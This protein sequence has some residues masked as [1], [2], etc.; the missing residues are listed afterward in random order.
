MLNNQQKQVSKETLMEL[1]ST[2]QDEISPKNTE[3]RI[4]SWFDRNTIEGEWIEP[5]FFLFNFPLMRDNGDIWW[6]LS[7]GDAI[8]ITAP[9]ATWEGKKAREAIWLRNAFEIG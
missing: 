1:L 4:R 5:I 6:P 3:K 8:V 7:N 9:F 2:Y